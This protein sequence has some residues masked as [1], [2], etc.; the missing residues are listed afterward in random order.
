MGSLPKSSL[1]VTPIRTV[2]RSRSRRA[3]SS[4]LLRLAISR[5]RRLAAIRSLLKSWLAL[6]PN[7]AASAMITTSAAVRIGP[8]S[9]PAIDPRTRDAIDERHRGV[10]QQHREREAVGIAA[11]RADGVR[12]EADACAVEETAP[13]RGRRRHGIGRDEERAEHARAAEEMELRRR[14]VMRID[15][16]ERRRRRQE[17][18][19]Q[20]ER[21]LPADRAREEQI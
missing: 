11:P 20:R 6:M 1:S 18:D 16:V 4:T 9:A 12:E 19:E 13:V 21:D 3:G 17:A 14:V 2:A 10:H 5:A 15:P 7:Q 8:P